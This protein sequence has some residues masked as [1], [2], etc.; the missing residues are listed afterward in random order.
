MFLVIFI[1]NLQNDILLHQEIESIR[2]NSWKDNVHQIKSAV[3]T[4]T[5][6]CAGSSNSVPPV[7]QNTIV[8]APQWEDSVNLTVIETRKKFMVFMQ[9][10]NGS[11][12]F[13]AT[14]AQSVLWQ[15]YVPDNWGTV[16]LFPVMEW[17]LFLFHRIQTSIETHPPSYPVDTQGH[18][19]GVKQPMR[20]ADNSPLSSAKI[21][22]AW[23]YISVC[24]CAFMTWG[25]FKNKD[26][27]TALIFVL[28]RSAV[29]SFFEDIK[30]LQIISY[31]SSLVKECCML[32]RSQEIFGPSEQKKCMHFLDCH[33]SVVVTVCQRLRIT[34]QVT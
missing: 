9:Q 11:T 21:K 33:F 27:F 7:R 28:Q 24:H 16:V 22:N 20:D 31:Y 25:L 6:R 19:P 8:L 26:N 10:G 5:Q 14:M 15:V 3:R 13:V 1:L 4:V 23:G 32:H 34:G 17:D 12:H 18:L 29:K 30:F 2:N